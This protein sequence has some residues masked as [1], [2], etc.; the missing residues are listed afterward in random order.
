[1]FSVAERK[2][3]RWSLHLG[4][5]RLLASRLETRIPF[6]P[7]PSISQPPHPWR[8]SPVNPDSDPLR[9]QRKQQAFA[10]HEAVCE[11]RPLHSRVQVVTPS[12]P[13]CHLQ[14]PGSKPSSAASRTERQVCGDWATG[15]G[16][17]QPSSCVGG[18][19]AETVTNER[20]SPRAL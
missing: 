7:L 15:S 17:A 6:R 9:D 2:P 4:L 3:R 20:P 14:R 1:M 11:R 16:S 19:V 8:E 18:S 12:S 13:A 5:Y 10:W